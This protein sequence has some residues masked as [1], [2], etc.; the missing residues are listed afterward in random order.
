MK[1]LE[2]FQA[3]Q[4]DLKSIMGGIGGPARSGDLWGTMVERATPNDPT[5]CEQKTD[6]FN[7]HNDNGIW[8]HYPNDGSEPGGDTS[9]W[10]LIC[11]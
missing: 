4:I 7:D 2:D 1:K 11:N 10:K 5:C 3:E 8:D 9:G 6:S